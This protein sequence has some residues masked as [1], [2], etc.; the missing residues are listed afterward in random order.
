LDVALRHV[1]ALSGHRPSRYT[2][3][4][5]PEPGRAGTQPDSAPAGPL[6]AF[7]H[8]L[9]AKPVVYNLVQWIVGGDINIRRLRRHLGSEENALV[10]EV[11]AG[12]GLYA[13]MLPPSARY[14]WLDMDPVKLSG[15]HATRPGGRAILGDATRIPLKAKS[16]DVAVCI[17]LSHH[18]SDDQVP[19]LFRELARVARKR[20]VFLDA[21]ARPSS[22]MS[23]LLW[24]YDRGSHP[25]AASVL[26]GHLS[27]YFDIEHREQYARMHE[28]LFCTARPKSVQ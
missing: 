17:S 14:L 25:R 20:I 6:T 16:V 5:A 24:R 4:L 10:L 15:F 1:R 2:L 26:T 8:Y 11:G 9:V 18:L 7:L 27:R 21:V 19:E 22:V 28:Y 13:A 3:I 23:R 12:T